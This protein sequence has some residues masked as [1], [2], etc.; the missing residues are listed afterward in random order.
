MPPELP[1]ILVADDDPVIRKFVRA[2]LEPVGYRIEEASDG[3]EVLE[4]IEG[5]APEVLILDV[6]MPGPSGVDVV[7][8]LAPGRV[9]V[10]MLT[11]VDDPDVEAAAMAAGAQAF[12]T[13]P[14]SPSELLERIEGLVG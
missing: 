6:L 7:R 10:L 3:N 2:V 9:K 11:A 4:R 5:L 8:E 13:K 12:L 1:C 14:F